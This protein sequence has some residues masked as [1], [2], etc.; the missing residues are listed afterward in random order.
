ME[1]GPRFVGID[2]CRAHLDVACS[3]RGA[4]FRRPNTAEGIEILVGRLKESPPT[5]VVLESTAGLERPAAIAL[6][7]GGIPVRIVDPARVRHF[8]KSLG[9][10]AKTDRLDALAIAR[11][12]EGAKPGARDLPDEATRDLQALI[13]R[14]RQLVG[15]RVSEENRLQQTTT[16]AVRA[17]LQAH[18]TYLKGQIEEVDAS[19]ARVVEA[20]E[21]WKLRDAVLRSGPGIG[22]Q[23]SRMLLGSLPELGSLG[24]KKIAALVGVAPYPDESGDVSQPRK[25]SGGR[26][27]VR[28][29]L[30]MASLTAVRFNPELRAFYRRLRQAGKAAKLAIT[31]VSRK[32]LTI[33]NA[34]IRDMKPWEPKMTDVAG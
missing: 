29:T 26:A 20:K 25:I 4:A 18:L 24:G 13:D 21:E 33:V 17:N 23:T 30:Y 15:M 27:N 7:D 31:A 34:M 6:A 28:T 11:S 19:V 22:P 14:R 10:R 5:L 12:A 1:T 16:A 32:L 8:A 3:P 2:V 9:Q